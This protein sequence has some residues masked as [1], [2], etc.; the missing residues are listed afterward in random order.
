M[1]FLINKQIILLYVLHYHYLSKC[2]IIPRSL[3]RSLRLH[4]SFSGAILNYFPCYGLDIL[5]IKILNNNIIIVIY[6]YMK[7]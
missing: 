6:E 4:Q 3:L 1:F 5:C 2:S 7:L